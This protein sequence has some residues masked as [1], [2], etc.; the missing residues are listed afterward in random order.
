[1]DYKY[2]EKDSGGD[3]ISSEEGGGYFNDNSN[4]DTKGLEEVEYLVKSAL[5]ENNIDNF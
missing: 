5:S 4:I 3:L 2:R 1:M